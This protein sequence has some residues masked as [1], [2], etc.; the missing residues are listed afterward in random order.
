MSSQASPTF[1]VPSLISLG[2]SILILFVVK[3]GFAIF[4]LAG[5]A[6]IFGLIGLVLSLSPKVRGGFTSFIGI[7]AGLIGLIIAVVK[8]FQAIF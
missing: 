7:G 2:A 4:L 8:L 3:G 5:V 1:S 6:I